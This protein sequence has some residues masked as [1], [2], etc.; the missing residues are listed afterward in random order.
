M[1]TREGKLDVALVGLGWWGKAMVRA[2]EGSDKMRLVTAVDID[3]ATAE[4]ARGRGVG[5]TTDY[6]AALGDEA[7]E[8]VILCTPNAL[9]TDQVAR[10]ARAQKHVYCEK[11]LALKRREALASVEICKANGVLLGVGHEL[12][13]KPPVLELAGML[14]SGELGTIMQSEVTFSTDNLGDLPA[15]HWRR[16]EAQAPCGPLT[17]TA[18]HGLDLCVSVHGAAESVVASLRKMAGPAVDDSL[19]ILVHFKDGADALIT[20][21]SGSPF[22]ARFAVFGTKGWVQVSDKAHPEEPE[23]WILT[24]RMRGGRMES[25]ESPPVNL[26]QASLEAFADAVCGRAPYPI[27]QQDMIETIAIL[28][29]IVKSAASG[30]I[31]QV[32]G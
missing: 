6:D 14:S 1:H 18:V 17:A 22:S 23:G 10:A 31:E 32:E 24:K 21:L 28:E 27:A 11:P 19:S 13:F 15:D 9:H 8:A 12:R 30:R 26:V 25:V 16:S 20:S 4:F 29:A 7:V 2:L 5:F 3:P